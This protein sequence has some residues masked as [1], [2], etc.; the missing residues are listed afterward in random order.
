MK[1]DET[2]TFA[3]ADGQ[4]VPAVF[5]DYAHHVHPSTATDVVFC[6]GERI[7]D[8]FNSPTAWWAAWEAA[9]RPRMDP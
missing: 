8:W 1:N 9:G 3:P 6:P 5:T 2:L 7:P 4:G